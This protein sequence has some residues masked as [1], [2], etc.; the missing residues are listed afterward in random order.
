M[1]VAMHTKP[2]LF[3]LTSEILAVYP[4]T[5]RTYASPWASD[6]SQAAL[7]PLAAGH[8]MCARG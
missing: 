8:P 4:H 7:G 5:M 6:S 1:T 2:A 3:E